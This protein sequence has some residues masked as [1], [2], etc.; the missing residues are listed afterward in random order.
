MKG[1]GAHRNELS[2]WQMLMVTLELRDADKN[3]N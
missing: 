1:G 3:L 2:F